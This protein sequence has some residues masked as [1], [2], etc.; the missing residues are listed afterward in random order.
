MEKPAEIVAKKLWHRGDRVSARDLFDLSL[1][2]RHEPEALISASRQLVR[3]RTEFLE[4]LQ[5]RSAILKL[6]FEA[7]DVLTYRPIYEDAAKQVAEFLGD[8]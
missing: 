8:L 3:Y 6:Q 4:Q 1:V 2:I 7:I 5:S